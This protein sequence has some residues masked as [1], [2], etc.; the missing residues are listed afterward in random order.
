MGQ[1]ISGQLQYRRSRFVTV[2]TTPAAGASPSITVPAGHSWR[3]L[4]IYASLVTGAAVANREAHLQVSDGNA[5][6]LDVPPAAVQAASLTRSYVWYPHA[7]QV[8]VGTGQAIAVPEL[9]LDAPAVI[10]LATGAIDA[11]DQWTALRLW[12][13]DST[14]KWGPIDVTELGLAV[15]EVVAG[16]AT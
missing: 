1:R 12:I 9:V 7:A 4:S 16:Q 6:Y 8:A 13:V 14:E 2:G 3:V 11:A 15:L 10:S 5:V